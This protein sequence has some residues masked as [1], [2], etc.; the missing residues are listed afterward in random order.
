MHRA[1]DRSRVAWRADIATSAQSIDTPTVPAL[2]DWD[3][4]QEPIGLRKGETITLLTRWVVGSS[5]SVLVTH[6]HN[7]QP[8]DV[9]AWTRLL[10]ILGQENSARHITVCNTDPEGEV[11]KSLIAERAASFD[12]VGGIKTNPLMMIYYEGISTGDK[13]AVLATQPRMWP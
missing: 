1:T 9:P 8:E 3:A 7:L 10:D 11:A 2:S 5:D 4:K 6:I 13:G 12:P